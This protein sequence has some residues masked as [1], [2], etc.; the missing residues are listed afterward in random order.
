MRHEGAKIFPRPAFIGLPGTSGGV[1]AGLPCKLDKDDALTE[2]GVIDDGGS[3][4]FKHAMNKQSK[5]ELE[6]PNGNRYAIAPSKKNSK[7]SAPASAMTATP[8]AL[9]PSTST[10]RRRSRVAFF[11]IRLYWTGQVSKMQWR[12]NR[13][14]IPPT[15]ASA[16]AWK[17][18]TAP[19]GAARRMAADPAPAGFHT[20]RRQ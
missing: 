2:Q 6:L 13:A 8:I 15:N 20:R 9:A 3:M 11:P 14:P 17:T 18:L 1:N 16:V 19:A 12:Q 5:Y 4:T 10:V 7:T